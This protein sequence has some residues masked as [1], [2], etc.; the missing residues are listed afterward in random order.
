MKLGRPKAQLTAFASFLYTTSDFISNVFGP[1]HVKVIS[2]KERKRYKIC[3][4]L[5]GMKQKICYNVIYEWM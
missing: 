2:K 5:Y 1:L 3:V 4:L